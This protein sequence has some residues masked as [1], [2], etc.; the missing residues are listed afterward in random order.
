MRVFIARVRLALRDALAHDIVN[1]SKAAAY[2]A[3]LMLFPALLVVTTVLSQ[4]QE[5]NTVMGELRAL[6]EQILPADTMDLL[7]AAVLAHPARSFQVIL[8][9]AALSFFASLGVTLSLMEG[10]RRAYCIQED[11]WSFWGRRLR[12][13]LLVPTVMIPLSAA[14]LIII[15][16][17]QIELWMIDAAGHELRH[18]VVFL[19]RIV[20]WSVAVGTTMVVLVVLYHFGIR[21][22]E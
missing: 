6:F 3:M 21:R 7:Q 18:F 20:R 13:V 16:G 14:T 2:S 17:H 11:D 19:W 4:A 1:T 22:K 8:S 12:A 9:A 10:F 15:F 5:G